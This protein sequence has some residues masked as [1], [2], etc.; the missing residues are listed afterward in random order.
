MAI[1][2][3]DEKEARNWG[4]FCHLAGLLCWVGVPFGNILG[5]LIIWLVKKDEIPMVD[6]HG[7]ES[8]N[9]QISA[10]IYFIGAFILCFLLIGIPMLI[11]VIIGHV[12][13]VIIAAV[14]VSNG[15]EYRYPFTIRFIK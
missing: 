2:K 5:P 9:F 8:L 6:E 3:V 1:K 7:K 11:A 14:K 4:M 10:T 12:V 13:L 15:E